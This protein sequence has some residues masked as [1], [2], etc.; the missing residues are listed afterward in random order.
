M[1]KRVLLS[2]MF[3]ASA[4]LTVSAQMSEDKIIEFI[5]EQQEKGVPQEQIVYE[6]NRRGVTIQQLQSMREKYEKQQSTGIMGNTLSGD[7]TVQ[8]RTRNSANSTLNLIQ[9]ED[10]RIEATKMSEEEKLQVMYNES[11]FLFIDSMYLLK[12]SFIFGKQGRYL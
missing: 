11:M 5:T 9:T 6:L 2:I 8:S 7:K 3:L 4:A 1:I 10:E 12:Q